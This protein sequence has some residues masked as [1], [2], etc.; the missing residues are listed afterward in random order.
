M[1]EIGAGLIQVRKVLAS[2]NGGKCSSSLSSG[3]NALA[4]A[5]KNSMKLWRHR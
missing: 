5:A 1:G 3:L 4:T 2:R